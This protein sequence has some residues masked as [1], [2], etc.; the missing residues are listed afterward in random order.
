MGQKN[1]WTKTKGWVRGERW[2]RPEGAGWQTQQA[3]VKEL[4]APMA[5]AKD[6]GPEITRN[7]A[8]RGHHPLMVD[9]NLHSPPI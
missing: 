1:N 6:T 8:H 7:T 3:S 5:S 9:P 4:R 2:W